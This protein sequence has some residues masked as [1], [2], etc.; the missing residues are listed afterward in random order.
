MLQRV[1]HHILYFIL[2]IVLVWIFVNKVFTGLHDHGQFGM[3][4]GLV[5]AQIFLPI[6]LY[7]TKW[8]N[9]II[10]TIVLLLIPI[11]LAK[12]IATILYSFEPKDIYLSGRIDSISYIV[13]FSS[14]ILLIELVLRIPNILL[15]AKSKI[16]EAYKSHDQV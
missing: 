5:I 4:V 9:K 15:G 16:K 12:W 3:I 14:S 7:K 10:I 8:W 1:K 2:T 6:F 11:P 13:F